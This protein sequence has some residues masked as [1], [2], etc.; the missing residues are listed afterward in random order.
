MPTPVKVTLEFSSVPEAIVLLGR[1]VGSPA[2][3]PA[4]A[5]VPPPVQTQTVRKGRSDKGQQRGSYKSVADPGANV[6][7]GAAPSAPPAVTT[8]PTDSSTV[9]GGAVQSAPA[10]DAVVTS[11]PAPTPSAPAAQVAAAVQDAPPKT[12][13]EAEAAVSAVYNKFGLKPTL[14]LLSRFGVKAI[15]ELNPSQYGELVAKCDKVMAGEPI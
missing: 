4:A 3:Q 10:P 8:Q 12:K 13:E 7:Q 5:E 1:L 9:G 15:R 6:A 14:E 11:A 2:A